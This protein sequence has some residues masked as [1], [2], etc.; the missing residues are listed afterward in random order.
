V[1]EANVS[2]E[3]IGVHSR[4]GW[5]VADVWTDV[6]DLVA[7]GEANARL[8]AAAPDMLAALEACLDAWDTTSISNGAIRT[9]REATRAAIANAK[10]EA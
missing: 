9:A 6:E 7:S 1:G 8:I 2:H 5:V 4:D 10:G 3:A